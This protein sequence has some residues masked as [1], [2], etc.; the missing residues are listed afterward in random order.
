MRR[1]NRLAD[2][3]KV[4]V[5]T[6]AV[7]KKQLVIRLRH[8]EERF[9]GLTVRNE[10]CARTQHGVPTD[11]SA[12][13]DGPSV[14]RRQPKLRYA[15][16]EDKFIVKGEPVN[17]YAGHGVRKEF[18]MTQAHAISRDAGV[19]LDIRKE[20]IENSYKKKVSREM[21]EVKHQSVSRYIGG[22]YRQFQTT[23]TIGGKVAK[24]VIDPRSGMNLVSEEAVQKLG[25]EIERHPTPYR[26]E[27]LTKGNEPTKSLCISW[28]QG[29]ITFHEWG[30]AT[31]LQT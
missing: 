16:A 11:H 14:C 5:R 27:W 23:C 2:M 31:A 8:M 26:L 30:G 21:A 3:N 6:E 19:N 12:D 4:Y 17:P 18:P 1:S 10:G 15:G 22:T 20:K 28:Y 24:L 9:G 25:L 13:M 29:S 7:R